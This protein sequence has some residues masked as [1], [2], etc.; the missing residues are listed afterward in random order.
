MT[1]GAA[2]IATRADGSA[3]VPGSDRTLT[4]SGQPATTLYAG[5]VLISDPVTLDVRPSSDLAVSLFFPGETGAADRPHASG[6]APPM[7]RSPGDHHGGAAAL[8]DLATTAESYYWLTGVDVL[9]PASAGALVTFGD[10][11]TDG[12]QSTPDTLGMW[13]AVLAA[14]LQGH[15]PRPRIGV[16][17][18]GISGNRVLGDNNSGLARLP[19]DVLAS[20]AVRWMTM[21]EGINDITAATPRRPGRNGLHRRDADC[22]LPAD[23]RDRAQPRRAGDRLHADPVRRLERLHGSGRGDPPGREPLDPHPAARS[24]R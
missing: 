17:N 6:C 7:C 18:A 21:I 3:I 13:P 24:T 9:A 22:R 15:A 5:Q 16:V 12:D 10:S 8:T 14:R 11:I 2:H 1:I 19:R 4:F 23:D 20:P